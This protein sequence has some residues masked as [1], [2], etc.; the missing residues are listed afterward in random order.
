[1]PGTVLGARGRRM[2]LLF[3]QLMVAERWG[4]SQIA[5]LGV[6]GVVATMIVKNESY[7]I[8]RKLRR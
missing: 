2:R 4:M 5:M 6:T 7:G 8:L 1:M 3:L